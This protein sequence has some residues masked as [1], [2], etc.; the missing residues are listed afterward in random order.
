MSKD[1]LDRD[2]EELENE[3]ASVL[4]WRNLAPELR[5]KLFTRLLMLKAQAGDLKARR[6]A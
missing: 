6:R 1:A 5:D 3:L 4:N 2:L